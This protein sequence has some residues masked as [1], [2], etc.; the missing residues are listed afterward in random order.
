[1]KPR[2]GSTCA[3]IG[4]TVKVGDASWVVTKADQTNQITDTYGGVLPTKQGNFVVVDF[5]YRN[6]GNESKT[7]HQQAMQLVDSSGRE[8]DPDTDTFGYIPQ[9]RNIFQE[10][11]NPGVTEN[12][13]VIFSV[14][15]G[16]AGYKLRLKDTN[17]FRSESNQG[18]VDLGF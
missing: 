12:G 13:Q 9:D 4:E 15:P 18:E 11:V 1:M 16:G 7:L 2:S 14:A 5:R 6:D 3:K 10:Q 17:L 8:S